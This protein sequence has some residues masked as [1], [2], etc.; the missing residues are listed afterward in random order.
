MK[1]LLIIIL[2]MLST[3]GV[4]NAQ[5][6]KV[7]AIKKPIEY[8]QPD[9]T[10]V[11]IFL[12]GDERFHFAETSDGYTLLSNSNN[13]YEYAKLNKCKNLVSSGKLAHNAD[14]RAKKEIKFLK[15]IEKGLKF[16]DEQMKNSK[17]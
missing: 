4:V 17:K 7:P 12:K 14:K 16:S 2:V 8:K 5:V 3:F 10:I 13:G 15:K 9:G 6:N 11:T 1:K